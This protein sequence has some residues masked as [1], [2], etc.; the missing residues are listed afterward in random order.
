MR[1]VRLLWQL[2]AGQLGNLVI[3]VSPSGLDHHP[4]TQGR[5]EFVI[6]SHP[7]TT[8]IVS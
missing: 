7:W 5:V 6:G 2:P 3:I 1:Q 4:Q 8:F